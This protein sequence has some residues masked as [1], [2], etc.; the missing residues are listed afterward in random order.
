MGFSYWGPL[1]VERAAF[2]RRDHQLVQKAVE[3]LASIHSSD[4]P[5][6]HLLLQSGYKPSQDVA[7]DLFARPNVATTESIAIHKIIAHEYSNAI[8][9]LEND[10]SIQYLQRIETITQVLILSRKWKSIDELDSRLSSYAKSKGDKL[11]PND[12][13]LS[14]K[15][16]L[17]FTAANYLQG[18]YLDCL[19]CFLTVLEEDATV[20]DVLTRESVCTFCTN[21]ELVMMISISAIVA[22]SL[23]HYEDFLQ[24]EDLA[25][26]YNIAQPFSKWLSLLIQTSYR[27]FLQEWDKID[28]KCLSSLFLSQKWREARK[29]MR[30]KIYVF[31]LRISNYVEIPYLSKTLQ[32]DLKTVCDDLHELIEGLKL[33]FIIKDLVVCYKNRYDIS[34]LADGLISSNQLLLERSE[35]IRM[36]NDVL[37]SK[38]QESIITNNSREED[39][40]CNRRSVNNVFDEGHEE[41]NSMFETD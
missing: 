29:S 38:V 37:R 17:L 2:N 36:Q 24:L 41:C 26:F 22:L 3:Y 13:L 8:G 20:I 16:K 11:E 32:I 14:T 19:R 7:E 12:R 35:A 34:N 40:N 1:L 23:D 21:D 25:P 27:D 9:L 39:R 5:H 15:I 18:R 31:Y 4:S 28:S 33:N 30:D 6:L 10:N